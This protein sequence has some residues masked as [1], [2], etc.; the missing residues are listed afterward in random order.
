MIRTTKPYS[1]LAISCVRR[2]D[3]DIIAKSTKSIVLPMV[4]L[5]RLATIAATISVPPVLPLCTNT[6]PSAI[7]VNI[8]PIQTFM[9]GCPGTSGPSN[10][11]GIIVTTSEITVAPKMVFTTNC[12]P[13]TK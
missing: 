4:T 10:N 13:T 5:V 3:D 12:F 2:K 11:G 6:S 8:P 1:T 7:P 9:N